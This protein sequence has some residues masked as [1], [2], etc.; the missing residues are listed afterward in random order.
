LLA[1]CTRKDAPRGSSQVGG[2]KGTREAVLAAFADCALSE[3]KEIGERTDRLVD[4]TRSYEADPGI[5]TQAKAQA[6]WQSAIDRWQQLE[7]FQ[8]GP[9]AASSAPGGKDIRSE[10]YAWPQFNRCLIEQLIVNRSY[11]E[12]DFSGQFANARGFGA[13]EYALFYAGSDNRCPSSNPLNSNGTWAAFGPELSAAKT[14]Y[15]RAAAEDVRRNARA[16]VAAWE[17]SKGNF[18]NELARAARGSAVYKTTQAGLNAV[19]DSLFYLDTV[20]KDT[21][22][23][24][25]LGLVNCSTSTCPELVESPFAGRS[26]MHVR[27]NLLGFRKLFAGCEDGQGL[28]FDDLL[29]D[30]GED[31][32]ATKMVKATEEAIAAVDAIEEP[33]LDLALSSNLERVRHLH[34]AVKAITDLL[35]T[36]FVTVLNLQLPVGAE[37]DND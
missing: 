23:A 22:I 35:K 19:S 10:I 28:G 26:K 30:L 24:A 1:T 8:F 4:A 17:P 16:L 32:L 9:A 31:D 14:G 20:V 25:P 18:W 15:A 3:A 21:K 2:T 34:S 5:E 6:A 13:I 37:G 7:V 29:R 27:N 12:D 33:S 36:E 11:L